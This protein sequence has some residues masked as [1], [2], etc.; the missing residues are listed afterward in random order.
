MYT[1]IQKAVSSYIQLNTDEQAY[2]IDKLQLVKLK[3]K[4][5]IVTAGQVCKYVYFV[6]KGCLCYFYLVESEEVTGLFFFENGW[7]TDYA[8]F[9]TGKPSTQFVQALEPA[10]LVSLSKADLNDLYTNVPKF[11]KLGHFLA[12]NAFLGVRNR[13]E[14]LTQLSP[15]QR[16]LKLMAER[17]KVFE[18][19]A[20]HYIAS[21][22]GIRPQSLSRIRK[23]I[24][25]DG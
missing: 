16:Y 21:Y 10:E 7:Y 5:F 1:Q 3:R 25:S 23:R 18:R 19:I 8:S 17:P 22:L 13:N 20:Q 11:E 12:E 24:A 4:E 14:M 2:F 9:L 15:E 6:N